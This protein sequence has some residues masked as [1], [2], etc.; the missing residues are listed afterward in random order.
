LGGA[1]FLDFGAPGLP[2]KPPVPPLPL[3]ASGKG[4]KEGEV[5]TIYNLF[6]FG[7]FVLFRHHRLGLVFGLSHVFCRQRDI[8]EHDRLTDD[9]KIQ[10]CVH[11]PR[12]DVD[13]TGFGD[14]EFFLLALGPDVKPDLGVEII[15]F[16][17][18]GVLESQELVEIVGMRFINHQ[19]GL[20]DAEPVHAEAGVP[21]MPPD[22][23]RLGRELGIKFGEISHGLASV[24]LHIF[25]G[26]HRSSPYKDFD[27]NHYKVKLKPNTK[28]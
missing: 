13:E 6:L 16:R 21:L 1:H 27:F 11:H 12:G 9:S 25:L 5:R 15:D 10:G 14:D 19:E 26:N 2:A 8:H 28:K 24:I 17:G 7:W 18:V 23:E 4:D 22:M 3:S 20:G